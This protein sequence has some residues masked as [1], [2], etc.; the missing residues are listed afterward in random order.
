MFG[1]LRRSTVE[2]PESDL[3]TFADDVVVARDEAGRRRWAPYGAPGT[4]F[5]RRCAL[6]SACCSGRCEACAFAASR[7]LLRAADVPSTTSVASWRESARCDWRGV[8]DRRVAP[9]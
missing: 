5:C 4:S 1:S 2:R 8:P 6:A 7:L 9:I 3:T